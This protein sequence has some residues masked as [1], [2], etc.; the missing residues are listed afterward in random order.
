MKIY[1]KNSVLERIKTNPKSIKNIFV[2]EFHPD[3]VYIHKKAK[4]SGIPVVFVPRSKMLKMGRS[5]NTQG[6]LIEVEDF[7]YTPYEELL[8][9]AVQKKYS[10]LF[11]DELTDPQNL[12]GILRTVACL[13][14]FVVVLPT[15]DSVSV[16]ESVL[17][18]ASG[19]D[20]YVP[21]ARVSNLAQAIK[22]A[23]EMGF[24]IA[25]G[26]VKDGKNLTATELPF[27]I[28]LV[29]G[30]EQKGIRDVIRKLLDL[31]LSVPMA[32]PRLSLNAAHAAALFCYEITRQKNQKS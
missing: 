18:V 31:E 17:R 3:A 30:S 24:W 6:L 12:G 9:R 29:V 20:N 14:D 4:E 10:L 28:A 1:G 19:A 5:L 23:K 26:V 15:H 13:G 21:V 32:Q 27:P 7:S 16:T 22:Q 8:E 11:L 2:E 25:G